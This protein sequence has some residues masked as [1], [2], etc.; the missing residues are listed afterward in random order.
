MNVLTIQPSATLCV[1]EINREDIS[2]YANVFDFLFQNFAWQAASLFIHEV[3]P[4][5]PK[6]EI[7]R[8]AARSKIIRGQKS[9]LLLS[10]ELYLN[11]IMLLNCGWRDKK[12]NAL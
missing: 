11:N 3:R 1:G 4:S 2:G 9:A 10:S 5:S 12:F 7:N 8:R 6:E